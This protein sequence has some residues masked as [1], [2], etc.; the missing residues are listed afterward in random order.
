MRMRRL[1]QVERDAPGKHPLRPGKFNGNRLPD[2]NTEA[3]PVA[4]GSH[5]DSH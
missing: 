3:L 1:W 2:V 4:V 5:V